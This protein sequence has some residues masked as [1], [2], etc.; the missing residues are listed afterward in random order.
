MCV[1]THKHISPRGNVILWNLPFANNKNPLHLPFPAKGEGGL[2]MSGQPTSI[3]ITDDSPRFKVNSC[4][5]VVCLAEDSVLL[6]LSTGVSPMSEERNMCAR[7]SKEYATK[8][9]FAHLYF[10]LETHPNM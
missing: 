10:T 3:Y 4:A 5:F 6:K 8:L 1:H 7:Q 9:F 2:E